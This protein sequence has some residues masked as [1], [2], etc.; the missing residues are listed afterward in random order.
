MRG[1]YRRVSRPINIHSRAKGRALIRVLNAEHEVV[2]EV[3]ANNLILA[4]GID[5]VA[6]RPWVEN[7][8]VCVLGS[9][10][11]VTQEDSGATTAS[12][13]TTTVTLSGGSFVFTDTATDAG[14]LIRWDTGAE[15]TIVTVSSPTS[16]VVANSATVG[17]GEFTVYMIQQTILDMV[18][19]V[20]SNTYVTAGS[21][22]G[23]TNS[24]P[25][26]FIHKRTFSFP[27]EVG[28][29]T[30]REVAF[31]KSITP[32]A[33]I[34][35]RIVLGTPLVLT[36]GQSMQ[37]VYTLEVTVSPSSNV[38][39]AAAI[40]G[41]SSTDGTECLQLYALATVDPTTGASTYD[42]DNGVS[43]EPSS[44]GTSCSVFLATDSSAP[45]AYGSAVDRSGGTQSVKTDTAIDAGTQ[46][47]GVG[48]LDKVVTFGTGEGNLTTWRAI[49][50]GSSTDGKQPYT[51]TG[52][53]FVF[54]F[55]QTKDSDHTLELRINY[56]WG[57]DLS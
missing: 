38:D 6:E 8:E 49:G 35:S 50:I 39:K 15:A 9:N 11:S 55:N 30:Y 45:A 2:Q 42:T 57:R 22:C 25:D 17:A 18:E 53:V 32:G 52:F 7:M 19:I 1:H 33:E 13:S 16:V 3:R 34:F 12:Q 28:L 43:W 20:R 5:M 44:E 21:G 27:E 14:K 37:V 26:I 54:D 46:S 40:L 56:T 48:N 36:A 10:G 24:T 4:G 23:T 51:A 41:W 47:P 29:V 31:A